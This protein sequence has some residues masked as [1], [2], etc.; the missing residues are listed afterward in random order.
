MP[1]IL[2][3]EDDNVFAYALQRHLRRDGH[4]VVP[5]TNTMDALEALDSD[6]PID[7]MITDIGMP[8]GI[9]NGLALAR[10]AA[11]KRSALPVILITGLPGALSHVKLGEWQILQK[12]FELSE[13]TGMVADLLA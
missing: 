11:L 12:P 10:M 6:Q 5:A 9:P 13:L 8:T 4:L 2:L 3:V 7:L 1:T